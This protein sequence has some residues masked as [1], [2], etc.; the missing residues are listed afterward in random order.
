MRS[1]LAVLA[2]FLALPT[3]DAAAQ[4]IVLETT[5]HRHPPRRPTP[6]RTQRMRLKSHRVNVLIEDQVARTSVEQVFFNPNPWPM[7]GIYVFPLPRGAAIGE[8]TMSMG[9]KQVKG[10]VLD[11]K[12]ARAI[13]LSIVHRRKDPGLLEFAG[14]SLIRARLFPIPA[15]GETKVTLSFSQVLEPEGGLVEWRYPMRS[16]KFAPGPVNIAGRIEIRAQAGVSN[17]FSPSHKLD[18]VR[19]DEN[20]VVASF[21]ETRSA[22]DRDLQVLFGLGRKD[23]GVV[24]TTHKPAGEDGYFLMLLA[25]NTSTR[26]TAVLPKDIVFVIDTSGSMGDRGGQ[27]MRQAKAALEYALGRL[28]ARDRFNV[29]SF[30]TEARPFRDGPIVAGK[31]NVQAALEYVRKLEATGG[32]AIHAALVSAL[33]GLNREAGRV[34]IVIFLTDGRPTIGP[35]GVETILK[36]TVRSNRAQARLFVFGVGD[37]LNATLLTSLADQHQGSTNFV[38]EREDIEVKVSDFVDKVSSPVLTDVTVDITDVGQH[39]VYPRKL[40]DLF[41]GQQ[42]VVVGRYR[43]DGARAIT[44]HG[45]LGAEL[46]SFVYEGT[47]SK[48]ARHDFLPRLWAVRKVGYLLSEIRRNGEKK[49]LVDEIRKLGIRHGIV[50]P[51]TSFLVVE[52]DELRRRSGRPAA[53]MTPGDSGFGGVG[54]GSRKRSLDDARDALKE[55]KSSG[56]GAVAGAKLAVELEDAELAKGLAGIGVKTVAGKTFRLEEGVWVDTALASFRQKHPKSEVVKVKYLDEAYVALLDDEELAR[57]FSV[58]TKLTVVHNSR[59]YEIR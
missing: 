29:I 57:Y 54:G 47:F 3:L 4:G 22:A 38:A 51:Y 16:D 24:L 45:R 1:L 35:T 50:T 14:R 37:Q 25:P 32:T 17:V 19:K 43:G 59:I 41:K 9:G 55:K 11:A 13:Y 5:W 7:E 18:I 27:K 26:K 15:R 2:L 39:D 42:V 28:D 49:E 12:R 56:R 30:S 8:F 46:R 23:F 31:E 10:E 36:D 58:G 52:E 6:R 21:E 53:P 33:G 44:L 48:D 34:P 20:S 40:G